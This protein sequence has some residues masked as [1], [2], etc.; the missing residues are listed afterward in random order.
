MYMKYKR[1]LSPPKKTLPINKAR[2]FYTDTEN[3]QVQNHKTIWTN[4]PAKH[5]T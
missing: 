2:H 3:N 1:A 5:Q 4:Y